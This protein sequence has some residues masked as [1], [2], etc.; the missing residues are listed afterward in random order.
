MAQVYYDALGKQGTLAFMAF[1]LAA[2]FF[3]GLAVLAVASRQA[4][5]FS[6]DGALPFSTFL[7]QVPG[8]FYTGRRLSRPIA[9]VAAAFC[10]FVIVLCMFPQAGPAPA[11]DGMNY[12]VVVV[13]GAVWLGASLH[14]AASARKWYRGPK[15]TLR[16]V[17][18]ARAAAE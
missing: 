2:Q 8:A 10:A 1:L 11:P 17:E 14:Y 13:S 5:A 18:G 16:V 9:A 3:M 4:W 12:T 6:R 15:A 7:R